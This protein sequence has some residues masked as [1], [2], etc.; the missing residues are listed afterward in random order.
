MAH[1]ALWR[2]SD[3]YTYTEQAVDD[4][5]ALIA[6]G[7]SLGMEL[8]LQGDGPCP[9]MLGRRE[10]D[11]PSKMPPIMNRAVYKVE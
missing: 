10:D 3:D 6:F 9:Y 11:D 2:Q 1:Y 5:Q 8:S 4:E 7:Q